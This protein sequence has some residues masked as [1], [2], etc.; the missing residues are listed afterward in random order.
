MGTSY[1]NA[2]V[3]ITHSSNEYR[4]VVIRVEGVKAYLVQWRAISHR[5]QYW[6]WI[7]S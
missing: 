4:V 2:M 6:S 5:W 3:F 7:K 1:I